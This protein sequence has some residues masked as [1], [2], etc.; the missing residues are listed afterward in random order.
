MIFIIFFWERVSCS[1]C[2]LFNDVAEVSLNSW[3]SGLYFPSAGIDYRN[4]PPFLAYWLTFIFKWLNEYVDAFLLWLLYHPCWP[5]TQYDPEP[6]SFCLYFSNARITGAYHHAQVFFFLMTSMSSLRS[7][8]VFTGLQRKRQRQNSELKPRL[9][10]TL[11]S[12]AAL[13][14]KANHSC[15]IP[16]FL[17]FSSLWS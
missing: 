1:P 9:V 16:S 3:S 17:T 2:W 12:R 4:A 15:P 14:F 11:S 6:W 7:L 8:F 10:Y 5:W 13:F